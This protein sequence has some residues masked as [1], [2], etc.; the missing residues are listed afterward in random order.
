M[1]IDRS[2]V[3]EKYIGNSLRI[4]A[5]FALQLVRS[6]DGARLAMA[7][8]GLAY[9]RYGCSWHRFLRRG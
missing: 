9:M 4:H 5:G 3:L 8:F 6:L 1:Q 2:I 7:I